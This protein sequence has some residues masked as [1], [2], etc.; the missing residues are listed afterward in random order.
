MKRLAFL[1]PLALGLP[2]CGL[3]PVYSGGSSG[4]VAQSLRSVEVAPI[5]GRAGWLVRT[6]LEER[7]GGPRTGSRYRLQ[8]RLDDAIV[9]FMQA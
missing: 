8:G 1:L 5:E 2:G 9:G 4:A 7:L 6:A 3:S